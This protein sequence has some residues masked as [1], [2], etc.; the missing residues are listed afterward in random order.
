MT[1]YN[2][3]APMTSYELHKLPESAQDFYLETIIAKY[4]PRG[5]DLATMLGIDQANV[6]RLLSK[7]PKAKALML[8]GRPK[9]AR[10]E[11]L[12][13]IGA[14]DTPE[15]DTT[16]ATPTP[17]SAPVDAV[18]PAITAGG[19]TLTTTADQL[20]AALAKLIDADKAYTFTV[21]FKERE[22]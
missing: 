4:K 16:A 11:W 15:P 14:A 17:I 5:I 22:E 3:S 6:T 1:S 19:I 12:S 9:T 20:Q 2:T 7:H 18:M 10:P 13:F 21:S 8:P